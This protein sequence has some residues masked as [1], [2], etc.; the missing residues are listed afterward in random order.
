MNK[1]EPKPRIALPACPKH[2]K[3]LA[4]EEWNRLAG[5]LVE[6]G[7]ISNLDRAALAVCCT[8]Y[9]DYVIA[10]NELAGKKAVLMSSKGGTYQ[11]PWVAIKR[12]SMEQVIKFYAEFGMTPS[13]RSR[14]HAE[15]PDA[16]DEMAGF[17]FGNRN[18]KVKAKAKQ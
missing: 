1:K 5:E 12:R 6:L 10:C 17:L 7:M 15:L 3:G 14:V 4:R 16:E 11:N 8:A 2:L 18:V 9:A 13:S